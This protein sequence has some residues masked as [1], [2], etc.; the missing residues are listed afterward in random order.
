MERSEKAEVSSD[1][2]FFYGDIWMYILLLA[3][4]RMAYGI[5]KL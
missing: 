1:C 4:N 5:S 3:I 2:F